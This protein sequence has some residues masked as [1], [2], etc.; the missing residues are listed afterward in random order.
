MCIYIYIHVLQPYISNINKSILEYI[1]YP[2]PFNSF[3][4][5]PFG[6]GK[7]P[8][9]SIHLEYC[10]MGFYSFYVP[11]KHVLE[12]LTP[13]YDPNPQICFVAPDAEVKSVIPGAA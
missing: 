10:R 5:F 8:Y 6:N 4:I 1:K 9:N 12:L 13:I 11:K 2:S 7:H 3:M